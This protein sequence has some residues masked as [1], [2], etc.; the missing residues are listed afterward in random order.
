MLIGSAVFASIAIQVIHTG[1]RFGTCLI[2]LLCTLPPLL[3]VCRGKFDCMVKK[4]QKGDV[5]L[6]VSMWILYY[7]CNIAINQVLARLGI[8]SNANPAAGQS[9]DLVFWITVIV[10]L[11]GE[12]LLKINC[13]LGVLMLVFQA[14]N[15]RKLGIIVGTVC[16]LALFGVAHYATYGNLVQVLVIQ[17]FGSIFHLFCYLKTKS[18]LVG[19]AAHVMTDTSFFLLG[20]L[21]EMANSYRQAK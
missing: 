11:F 5:G 14:T 7:I 10:Q 13:F 9:K 17:G 8:I 21:G 1:L 3:Y 18:I 6:A 20:M 16:A 4:P 2:L 19:Y 15:N 12:E